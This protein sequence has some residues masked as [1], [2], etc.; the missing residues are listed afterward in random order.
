VAEIESLNLKLREQSIRDPLT[1]VFNRRY[2]DEA[3]ARDV[4]RANRMDESLSIAAL[5]VDRF[6]GVNDEWGHA[7]G[8][9]VLQE[10]ARA[11]CEEGRASDLVC[12]TGGEEFVVVLPGATL[13]EACALAERWRIRIAG[14]TVDAGSGS[15]IRCTVSL[16]VACFRANEESI[17]TALRRADAALYEA[18]RTGRDRVVVEERAGGQGRPP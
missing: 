13:K 9:L 7:V 18:K 1:G 3:I 11:L 15:M 5:D 12:R 16:G 4:A 2:L 17:D 6:K 8:D 14:T 10:V